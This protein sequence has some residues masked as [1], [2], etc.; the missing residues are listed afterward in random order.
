MRTEDSLTEAF[1]TIADDAPDG[2]RVV[3]PVRRPRRMSRR[4]VVVAVALACLAAIAVPSWYLGLR[5]GGDVPQPAPPSPAPPLWQQPSFDLALSPGWRI[6]QRDVMTDRS[7]LGFGNPS[8]RAGCVLAAYAPGRFD[9]RAIPVRR[10]ATTV[11]GRPGLYAAIDVPFAEHVPGLDEQVL[12]WQYATNAWALVYCRYTDADQRRA[13]GA[14]GQRALARQAV[15][16]MR[17]GAGRFRVPLAITPAAGDRRTDGI[18]VYDGGGLRSFGDPVSSIRASVVLGSDEHFVSVILRTQ[19]LTDPEREP[20][21]APVDIDGRRGWTRLETIRDGVYE[22][23][24]LIVD[25]GNGTMLELRAFDGPADATEE[26]VAL[27]RRVRLATDLQ[28][29]STWFD[30]ADSL[31]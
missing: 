15:A 22:R 7:E 17:P 9:T 13:K 26:L 19:S 6:E 12:G 5:R 27:A 10:T 16:M 18:A 24:G 20:G 23:R 21:A 28:D 25:T 14:E 1:E 11:G 31:P 30:A 4:L 29:E 8:I 3:I 2:T